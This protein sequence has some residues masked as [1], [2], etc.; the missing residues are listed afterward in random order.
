MCHT[1]PFRASVRNHDQLKP[2]FEG[3]G[4]DGVGH[5]VSRRVGLKLHLKRLFSVVLQRRRSTRGALTWTRSSGTG[6]SGTRRVRSA[7]SLAWRLTATWRRR[8]RQRRSECSPASS[9]DEDSS[10]CRLT[11]SSNTWKTPSKHSRG[12][13]FNP[14]I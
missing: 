13:I 5:C 9:S 1:W 14:A 10:L 8:G 2:S 7:P 6:S 4:V 3:L 12:E 11:P